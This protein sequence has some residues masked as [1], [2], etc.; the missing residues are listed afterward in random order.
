MKQKVKLP[1]PLNYQRDVINLLDEDGV[2]FVTFLKSR[3]SGGSF[4]NKLLV[5]KW[6]LEN[7]KERIGYIT[8]T[9][10]LGKLFF[11]ELCESL[12][13]YIIKKNSTDLIIEFVTKTTVQFFSAESEDA[14]RGFQFEYLVIDEAA[15]Q[16]SD[17]F[18]TIVRPTILIKGKKVIMCSTPNTANGF[19]HQHYC[20]GIDDNLSMYRS[21]KITIEDNPFVSKEEI[22]VIKSTIPNRIFRQEYLSEFLDGDGAVFTNFKKCVGV[23]RLTGTY[24]AA[25]DYAKENDYTVLTIIN[26]L[27]EV[28]DIQRWTG[29]DY[30]VQIDMI[31]KHLNKWRPKLTISEENN[32]G[33]VINELLKKAYSGQI[34]QI[35]LN[36]T[37]KKDMIEG[38][39]VA[40]ETNSITIP[41]NETLFNELAGF[42]AT[43]NP[44]TQTVK[45][46]GR[47]GLHDDMVISLAYA[48]YA[49][50]KKTGTYNII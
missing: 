11:K 17:F 40:F 5:V 49:V 7:T 42:T 4:L 41:D 12:E 32:I 13:P 45:Y 2:K 24:Y 23:G 27:K 9:L 6:G 25:I 21:L 39:I 18:D 35:T 29:L 19:F 38:L 1:K 30:T 36:N 50:N 22:D 3:Q 31:V 47:S 16:K 33:S 43:Y 26:D 20:F 14:I 10:K 48:Y 34:K 44:S 37:F 15:F 28:V 8:P 46:G